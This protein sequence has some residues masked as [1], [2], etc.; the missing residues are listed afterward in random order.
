M[1]SRRR[2]LGLTRSALLFVISL[3]GRL[4]RGVRGYLRVITGCDHG[5][6]GRYQLVRDFSLSYN[7][8]RTQSQFLI[9]FQEFLLWYRSPCAGW[10][11]LWFRILGY[12]LFISLL[13][14]LHKVPDLRI[15]SLQQPV[16]PPLK[17]SIYISKYMYI[18]CRQWHRQ[19]H[20]PSSRTPPW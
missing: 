16:Q 2:G 9:D 18:W 1:R 7:D 20:T 8:C 19:Q 15:I 6:Y 13:N 4:W 12:H 3:D 17:I 5:P 14:P 10:V 11:F